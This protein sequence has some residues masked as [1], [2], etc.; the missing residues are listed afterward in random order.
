MIN[1][2][3]VAERLQNARITLDLTQDE[4]ALKTGTSKR[5]IQRYE[6]GR[7]M[8]LVTLDKICNGYDLV[9]TDVIG[10][11][12]DM[13]YL[14]T[15]IGRLGPNTCKVLVAMCKSMGWGS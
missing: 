14:A 4:A 11:Q 10:G 3:L 15:A 1:L 6:S 12:N 13:A 2:G 8:D 9:I 7:S 5:T